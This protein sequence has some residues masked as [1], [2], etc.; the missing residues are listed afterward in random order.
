MKKWEKFSQQE[1][2][3]IIST[4]KTYRQALEKLNYTTSSNNNRIIKE[5]AKQYNISLEHFRT[6]KVIDLTGHKFG[7]LT[8]IKQVPNKTK[9]N[10]RW[11]CQC[12]CGNLKQVD[13][14]HLKNNE[15]KSCGCL[16]KEITAKNNAIIKFQD[17]TGQKFGKLTVLYRAENVGLQPAWIC[18]C[19]CGTITHPIMSSNLKKGTTQSCGCLKSKGEEKIRHL[20]QI[21]NIDYQTEFTFDDCL[22]NKTSC[23]LRFDFA[24]LKNNKLEYLIEYHGVQHYKENSLF[25]KHDSFQERKYRDNLKIEYCKNHNIPLIIIP[26][27]RFSQLTIQDLKIKTSN[28]RKI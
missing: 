19:D 20:L 4:S 12:E 17:L 7:K 26:Y 8:V 2:I 5:I 14:Y 3:N 1:L 22:N 13:A 28:F 9:G 24:I 27:T 18:R 11:L 10:A 23:K 6:G 25:F 21:N 16:Q 15:I